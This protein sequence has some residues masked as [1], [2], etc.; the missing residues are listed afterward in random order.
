M[1]A[2]NWKLRNHQSLTDGESFVLVSSELSG[3][4]WA[5]RS[6]LNA[7][8][9]RSAAKFNHDEAT[10]KNCSQPPWDK[11]GDSHLNENDESGRPWGYDRRICRPMKRLTWIDN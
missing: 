4:D 6:H 9:A 11:T 10:R 1:S 3:I 7:A 5:E 2:A 8:E